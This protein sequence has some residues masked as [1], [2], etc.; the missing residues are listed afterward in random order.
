MSHNVLRVE[1]RKLRWGRHVARKGNRRMYTELWWGNIIGN[2]FGRLR[3]IFYDNI[4][5]VLRT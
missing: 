1:W 5:M 3:M 4:K 2:V